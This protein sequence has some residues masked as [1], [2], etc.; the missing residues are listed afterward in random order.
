ML[1]IDKKFDK[2][3]TLFTQASRNSK[4]CL[5]TGKNNLPTYTH[6]HKPTGNTRLNGERL[7]VFPLRLG[8]RQG[9]ML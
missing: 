9:C 4:E 8:T 3:P 2:T 6:T 5:S 1:S 7:N